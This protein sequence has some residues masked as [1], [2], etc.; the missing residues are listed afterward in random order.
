MPKFMI[1]RHMVKSKMITVEDQFEY[2]SGVGMLL[3]LLNHL[4][5]NIANA[6][7]GLSKVNDGAYPGVH[8]LLL[9]V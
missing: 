4:Q 6:T 9:Y 8:K 3:Y 2:W 7:R 5:P 1:A